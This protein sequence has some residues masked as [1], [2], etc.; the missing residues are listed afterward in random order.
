MKQNYV[1]LILK[2]NNISPNNT[3]VQF[4]SNAF[5]TPTKSAVIRSDAY[6]RI[7]D[8][9]YNQNKHPKQIDKSKFILGFLLIMS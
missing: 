1:V 6:N 2:Q 3:W 8:G 4:R 9:C 7:S 5:V